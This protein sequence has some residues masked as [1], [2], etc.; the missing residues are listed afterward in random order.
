MVFG[1]PKSAYDADQASAVLRSLGDGLVSEARRRLL[2]QGVL[3][4][5]VRD[6]RTAPGRTL[7]ISEALVTFYVKSLL[8]GLTF[9]Y[10]SATKTLLKVQSKRKSSRMPSPSTKVLHPELLVWKTRAARPHGTRWLGMSQVA[11]WRHCSSSSL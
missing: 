11:R 1:T 4:K 2:A 7:K 5:L 3:S 9:L 10:A 6:D 8:M